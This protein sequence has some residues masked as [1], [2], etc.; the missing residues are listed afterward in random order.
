[1]CHF[2][3]VPSLIGDG[4]TRVCLS[5]RCKKRRKKTR[6]QSNSVHCDTRAGP[7]GWEV[8]RFTPMINR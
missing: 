3:K 8:V 1:M 4:W 7:D 6:E 2:Q 5:R